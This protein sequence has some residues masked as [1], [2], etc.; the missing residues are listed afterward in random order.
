MY[1]Q[2]T[3]LEVNNKAQE[4]GRVGEGCWEGGAQGG[5]KEASAAES[6]LELVP[7]PMRCVHRRSPAHQTWERLKLRP[8]YYNLQF[9]HLADALNAEC[10]TS[11]LLI[12]MVSWQCGHK[13]QS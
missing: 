9:K 13:V 6:L 10:I 3:S 8:G 2:Y 4:G 12:H 1:T 11:D 5:R 7:H